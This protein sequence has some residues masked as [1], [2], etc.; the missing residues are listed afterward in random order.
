MKSPAAIEKIRSEF[1]PAL[2]TALDLH[3]APAVLRHIKGIV[4]E[5]PYGYSTAT[6]I[7]F[8]IADGLAGRP[9]DDNAHHRRAQHFVLECF[10]AAVIHFEDHKL[11]AHLI[12]HLVREGAVRGAAQNN[13]PLLKWCLRRLDSAAPSGNHL[14]VSSVEGGL[15]YRLIKVAI[16]ND[17]PEMISWLVARGA[18]PDNG[19]SWDSALRTDRAHLLPLLF[20]HGAATRPTSAAPPFHLWL[21][22]EQ[23]V[24][25][26]PED[27]PAL[28]F[29][30]ERGFDP[31]IDDEIHGSLE[32]FAAGAT[33]QHLLGIL[34]AASAASA[35]QQ[36][37][38]C[39]QPSASVP[40][41]RRI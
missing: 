27:Y 18:H 36:I 6:K 3:D 32:D 23:A 22:N 26:S 33:G 13:M 20:E 7:L 24:G 25:Q 38:G 14:E 21:L 28:K 29:L 5:C 15:A 30:M 2:K 1:P 41:K 19:P 31:W 34:R 12:D 17:D 40:H 35:A 9:E 10:N 37:K 11:G 4:V 8:N 39:T 16:E